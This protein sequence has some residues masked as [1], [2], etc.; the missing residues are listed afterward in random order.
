MILSIKTTILNCKVR[1]SVNTLLR[2][3]IQLKVTKK[4]RV[5]LDTT[6]EKCNSRRLSNLITIQPGLMQG[7]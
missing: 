5:S 6:L 2:I 3:R 7:I 4:D 1:G